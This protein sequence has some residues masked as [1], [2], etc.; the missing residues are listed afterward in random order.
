M[1][2]HSC[3]LVCLDVPFEL[4]LHK[5]DPSGKRFVKLT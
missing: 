1:A 5:K 3:F 4:L 2:V